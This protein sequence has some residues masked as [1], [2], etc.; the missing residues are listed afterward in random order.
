MVQPFDGNARKVL[1]ALSR[2]VEQVSRDAGQRAAQS[3]HAAQRAREVFA[4]AAAA[5]SLALALL[6]LMITRATVRSVD[7]I[8]KATVLVARGDRSVNI[9]RLARRD[10]LGAIVESLQSFQDNVARVA[11][12]AHHD[13]LTGLPNRTLFNDRL[14]NALGQL[15]RDFQFAVLCLDLDRFKA[16]NDTLG[17]PVGDALLR[18]VADRV[19]ACIREG[20]TVARLGGDEFAVILQAIDSPADEAHVAERIIAA[21]NESFDIDGNRVSIGCSIGI[22]TAPNDGAHPAKLLKSADTA[23]YR[24]KSEGRNSFRFFEAAMDAQLQLRRELEI[25]MR[26]AI[27]AQEFVLYYQP[28]VRVATMQ[29]GGFEALLR[30]AHPDRGMI[31]PADFIPVAEETGLIVALGEWALM[32][33]CREA[34]HWPEPLNVAVNLSSVQFKDMH[35][36]HLVLRALET[37]GLAPS[38]LE[39]EITESVLLHRSDQ[40]MA[41]LTG[42]RARGVRISMD[43]FG[44]GYSSLSYLRSFPFDKIKIDQSF[45]RDLSE[46]EESVAIVR[47]V[48]GLSGSLG[49]ATTAEGVETREQ[50]ERLAL[51]G[52]TEVQGYL[53]GRPTP[54]HD[55]PLT[56]AEFGKNAAARLARRQE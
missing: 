35:L 41:V 28:L 29:I 24:A 36:L 50:F 11:F 33:A 7:S 30:W 46:K 39:L 14:H 8:A 56:L 22:A 53:F 25:D 26:R 1:A 37:S 12:L 27:A 54:A 31:S 44:T 48:T 2:L 34:A 49:V 15:G 51:E 47:A 20:D 13:A 52:C 43:D 23:L 16:V 55:V 17:H 40:T 19:Y 10:E 9:D 18:Q 42:L 32:Q 6:C 21:L 5:V 3:A 38:R 45:V 4:L